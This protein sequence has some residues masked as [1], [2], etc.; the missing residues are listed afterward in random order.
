[1]PILSLCFRA[2][3]YSKNI[4]A[5]IGAGQLYSQH[6]RYRNSALNS[7]P[8]NSLRHIMA[9]VHFRRP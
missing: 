6:H 2:D 5:T 9:M 4:I 7:D 1:M 3:I 8:E